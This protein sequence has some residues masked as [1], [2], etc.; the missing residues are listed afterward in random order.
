[1]EIKIYKSYSENL[2]RDMEYK[3]YGDSGQPVL[4][5][6]SQDGRYFDYENFGMID[7]LSKYIDEGRIRVICVDSIDGETWSDTL[8]IPRRRIEK[9]ERWFKYIVDEL[10]PAVRR[11]DGELFIVTG[12]SMGGYHAAN[13]FFR[14]PDFFS[15]LLSL[16]GLYHASFFFGEYSD[17]LVYQNSPLDFIPN[18]PVEHPWMEKYRHKRIILCVGQG[19]W[20]EELLYS[21][22]RL[23]D[24]LCAKH[25]P[26]WV[27]YW[28]WDVSH[29][30]LWWRRQLQYF[31]DKILN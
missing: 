22:R 30:W 18:M 7:V 1:M 14:C 31:M 24:L 9:H 28:G 16:S 15:V 27:D 26:A 13:F 11:Y 12:C 4:V 10:L 5:F 20:E 8:E 2:C 23:D 19:D 17:E 3:V 6:P 21:T 29:D 25:V